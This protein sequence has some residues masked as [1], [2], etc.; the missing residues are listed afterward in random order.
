[1]ATIT[2]VETIRFAAAPAVVAQ[3]AIRCG[4]AATM[5]PLAALRR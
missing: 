1:M 5:S 2:D 4:A 3:A